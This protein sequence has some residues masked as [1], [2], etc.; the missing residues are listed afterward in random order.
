MIC[1]WPVKR[2]PGPLY[3]LILLLSIAIRPL[4][5]DEAPAPSTVRESPPFS[6]RSARPA[7]CRFL[8]ATDKH[9]RYDGRFDFKNPQSVSTI[10]Q[11][12]RISIDFSGERI[13]FEFGRVQNQDFFDLELD[14]DSYVLPLRNNESNQIIVF[15]KARGSG[16]HHLILT[17]RSEA[18]AGTAQ[19]MGI[20][21]DP[22]GKVWKPETP[23]YKLRMEFFG[24]SITAGACDEDGEVDQWENRLTH[25]SSKSYAAFTARAFSADY[26]NISV[27]GMGIV[28]GWVDKRAIQIWDRIY[29]DP[30]S[31]MADLSAWKPDVVFVNLGENDDS[32]SRSKKQEFPKAFAGEY[33]ALVHAIRK[34]CPRAEII[35]LRGGM[36]GG[37]QSP[38]LRAAWNDATSQLEA[39]DRRTT[40]FVFSHWS[41]NH[42][43]VKDHRVMAD[44]LIAWL[45]QQP[46]MA[47]ERRE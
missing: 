38:E 3:P 36:S 22:K 15:E 12:S 32:F 47:R 9:F 23:D 1:K 2:T 18:D 16:R 31:P 44:E 5:G 39:E 35:L 7:A 24:D 17:K 45:Q 8:A 28:T 46:F 19:F 29:P 14:G 10:W 25:N 42:P 43:R 21:I 33:L 13:A 41:N 26:R 20:E 40:H 37:A 6:T 27:S 4:H 30:A 34:A 11:G